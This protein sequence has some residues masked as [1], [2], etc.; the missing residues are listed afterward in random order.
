MKTLLEALINAMLLT[1][2]TLLV[3]CSTPPPIRPEIVAAAEKPL[4]CDSEQECRLY[5]QRALFYVNR[6]SVFKVQTVTDS[7]IQTYSPR[8]GTTD[9]GYNVS[10]EPLL[11]GGNR[12]WIKVWCDNMF[13]CY[14]SITPEIARFKS[15]VTT[16][17]M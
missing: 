11:N 3:G 7:L 14:P 1:A 12:L 4:T 13:G 15:Y 10:R 5:W 8:G 16:G 17:R 9:V 2:L 6:V